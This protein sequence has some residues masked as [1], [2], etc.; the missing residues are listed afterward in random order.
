V[1][2]ACQVNFHNIVVDKAE[3]S[4]RLFAKNVMPKFKGERKAA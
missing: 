4:M 1:P 3:A 2:R